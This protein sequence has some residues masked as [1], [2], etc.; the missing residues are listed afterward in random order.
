MLSLEAE[1]VLRLFAAVLCGAI[2]GI[3]RERRLKSAGIR[4]H[5]IVALASSLMMMVSKYGF[6]DVLAY[7]S[8]SVD[9][10]RIAAGVVT[11][12][13]F[14]GG[15]VIMFRHDT[16]AIGL[17]TAA[18]LWATVGV[19]IAMGAGMYALGFTSTILM[20]VVQIILHSHHLSMMSETAGEFTVDF[21]KTKLSVDEIKA[22]MK[23]DGISVRSIKIQ[24]SQDK[25][26]AVFYIS[27]REKKNHDAL[28]KLMA[29][30]FSDDVTLY[31]FS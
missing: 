30:D 6:F 9:A 27:Y 3:E 15:G 17:T 20:Y 19:G 5:I 18:G 25:L 28:S 4:T 23:Q 13:G 26:T 7:D 21:G 11:A 16:S 8:I 29:Y 10:S 24:K 31:M 22:R 2:I 1:Y 12:I 14:L